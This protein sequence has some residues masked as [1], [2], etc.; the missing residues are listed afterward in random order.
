M[1]RHKAT[2]LDFK[3]HERV[4]MWFYLRKISPGEKVFIQNISA[5]YINIQFW[6]F[7][8]QTIYKHIS[9]Y[10]N[11]FTYQLPTIWYIHTEKINFYSPDSF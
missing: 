6:I 10:F 7:V 2:I 3:Q 11:D 9:R 8:N 5:F 4:I 1:Y